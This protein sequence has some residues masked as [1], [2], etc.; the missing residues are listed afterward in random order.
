M[1]T[2]SARYDALIEQVWQRGLS[3]VSVVPLY[4][5]KLLSGTRDWIE[6]PVSPYN[7]TA[8]HEARLTRP[9]TP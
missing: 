8:F 1:R 4:R 2:A 6:V 7:Q 5:R 3:D 9:A